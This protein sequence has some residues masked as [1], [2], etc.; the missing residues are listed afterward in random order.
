VVLTKRMAAVRAARE[1][2]PW[3][4]ERIRGELGKLGVDVSKSSIQKVVAGVRKHRVSKQTWAT[5][6]RHHANEI[7]ACDCLQTHDLFFRTVFVFVIVELG[8]RRMV[9]VGVT[10]SP[11]DEWT[12]R[13]L[14]EATPFGEGPRF[15]IRDNDGK[16]GSSFE[17]AA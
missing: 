2:A 1:N 7:W 13:Q 3:G 8:S 6:L 11:A 4:A 12:A 10:R 17:R 5:F 15:L 9:H 16:Y 14:R